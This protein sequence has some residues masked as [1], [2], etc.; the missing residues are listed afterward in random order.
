MGV[1][2]GATNIS[3]KT[4]WKIIA[5]SLAGLL[6]LLILMNLL[7]AS[8]AF[9]S[10]ETIAIKEAPIKVQ[11]ISYAELKNWQGSKLEAALQAFLIS[12]DA[13]LKRVDTDPANPIE[14]IDGISLSGTIADWRPVCEA[15]AVSHDKPRAFFENHFT[16]IE[17]TQWAEADEETGRKAGYHKDGLFTGYYEPVYQGSAAATENFSVPVLTKPDDLI[18]IELGAFREEYKGKKLAGKIEGNALVPYGDHQAIIENEIAAETLLWMNPDDLL[19]LQIQGSGKLIVDGAVKR[20][21]YAAQNGHAYTPVGRTLVRA[22]E[23]PLEIISMQSIREWLTAAEPEAAAAVRY[24]NASY[25]FFKELENLPDPELGPLGAQGVQLTPARSLAVDRRYYAMGTPVWVE[26]DA[27]EEGLRAGPAHHDLLIAQDTGGAIRG[28][29]RGD[30]YVGSGDE[31]GEKAGV[32]KREGRMTIL[33]PNA[34]ADLLRAAE[35]GD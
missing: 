10:R 7:W 26:L 25:V 9:K 20:I 31:A 30:F 18:S 6:A 14:N 1:K 34:V 33:V 16:P 27:V 29:V 8:G 17:I 12:C 24:S 22:G 23:I 13:M 2:N 3:D 21:G 15:A 28:P 32:F 5:L 19:F 11:A 4:P 35:A